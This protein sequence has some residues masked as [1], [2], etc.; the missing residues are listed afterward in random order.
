M[1]D[2]LQQQQYNHSVRQNKSNCVSVDQFKLKYSVNI[3]I[4]MVLT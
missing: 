4:M 2:I 1:P 3:S